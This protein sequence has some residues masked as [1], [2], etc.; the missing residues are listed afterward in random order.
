LVKHF[1]K[2]CNRRNAKTIKDISKSALDLLE[3]YHFPG[4]VRELENI[5]RHKIKSL[6]ISAAEDADTAE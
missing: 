6:G 4:N 5:I 2:K 1:I 3:N